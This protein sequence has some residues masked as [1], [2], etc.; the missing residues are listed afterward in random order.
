MTRIPD[1]D[2]VKAAAKRIAGHAR[3][4][5]LLADTPLDRLTGGRV[6]LKLETLQHTGSFKFRG[7]WNR[8]AQLDTRERA[9][10]VVAFSS[11]N[12]AQGIA[13][14]A[15]RLGI[16]ATIV[17]PSDAPRVKMQNT[18][19]MGAEVVEYD[20]VHESR[21]QIA[22]RLAAERGATLVPSFDD[23]DVIAGQ[24]TV[25]LEIAE[26]AQDLG[27]TL[28]DVVVCCSGGGLMA[29]IALAMT[30]LAPHARLWTAEPEAYD[31]HRRSLASGR[32]QRTDPGVPASI[33]DAL[34]APMPGELTYAINEP[35][36]RGGLAVSDDEVRHAI[37]FAA[38]I[39]K[40]VVEP[41]GAV[42]LACVLSGKLDVGDRTVAVTLSGGNVDDALLA[43]VLA[44]A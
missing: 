34:L 4:T 12:H 6:L 32:R 36:L 42:A 19:D 8:L 25:G 33:C 35:L 16:R 5:P 39:L 43:E 2:D 21:E 14:A 20:R 17:M 28:D 38:R 11:G 23:P 24:G 41:G 13:E 22:A 1:F 26:Q 3:R 15:R 29:G 7:A 44:R 30:R 9:A 37:A 18:R 10:G 40:V 31:D 27:L